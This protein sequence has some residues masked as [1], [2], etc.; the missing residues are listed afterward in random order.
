MERYHKYLLIVAALL[1]YAT[2]AQAQYK[3]NALSYTSTGTTFACLLG[4]CATSPPQLNGTQIYVTDAQ[5]S[6]GLCASGGSGALAMLLNGQWECFTSSA[7][8]AGPGVPAYPLNAQV[9]AGADSG[10][11]INA[12]F[13]SPFCTNGCVVTDGL[14]IPSATNTPAYSV[15]YNSP[16]IWPNKPSKLI[17][18]GL[19]N[20]TGTASAG[21]AV[22]MPG[23]AANGSEIDCEPNATN[24][25]KQAGFAAH[26]SSGSEPVI[27][28]GDKGAI[29]G[30]NSANGFTMHGCAIA[31]NSSATDGIVVQGPTATKVWLDGLTI[32]GDSG[33]TPTG[34]GIHI[35]GTTIPLTSCSESGTTATCTATSALPSFWAVGNT[36]NIIGTSVSGYNIIATITAIGPCASCGA[37]GGALLNTQFQYTAAGSLGNATGGNAYPVGDWNFLKL[38]Y[39]RVQGWTDDVKA[40]SLNQGGGGLALVQ[41]NEFDDS[42]NGS[43][44]DGYFAGTWNG[45][46]WQNGS[47]VTNGCRVTI[48]NT[49][50]G[51]NYFNN[52]HEN[53]TSGSNTGVKDLC[54]INDQSFNIFGNTFHAGT[55]GASHRPDHNIDIDATS[56]NMSIFGN[57]F[58][59]T[60]T[61]QV[62]AAG[63]AK[64]G[65]WNNNDSA[66]NLF[67]GTTASGG[68]ITTHIGGKTLLDNNFGY[69][70]YKNDNTTTLRVAGI[71]ASNTAQLG[72]DGF[73]GVQ[74]GGATSGAVSI[75]GSGAADT[76]SDPLNLL[77]ATTMNNN[78]GYY[79]KNAGGT[80]LRVAGVDAASIAQICNDSFASCNLGKDGVPTTINCRGDITL[81]GGN[82]TFTDNCITSTSLCEAKDITTP[83]NACTVA[84]PAAGSVA[85]TGTASDH[86]RTVCF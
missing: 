3:A 51:G 23:T 52:H 79:E 54:L 68:A 5:I 12:A 22:Q 77:G 15:P 28:I 80:G 21:G 34:Y 36:P 9:F 59:T 16:I 32:N 84:A 74:V 11:K 60:L 13:A 6:A 64:I 29:A 78:L 18:H 61:C 48:S 20:H 39:N 30:I 17:I 47:M 42:T 25:T 19:Y 46:A 8:G 83:G 37:G 26:P 85:I 73:A 81:S 65:Y 72:N 69:Y 40:S 82:G 31:G 35:E 43:L 24:N 67:C 1:L 56:N 10:A 71:D 7:S 44:F 41:Q 63:A 38:T 57:D 45:N 76:I 66:T 55:A 33:S 86:C 75:G 14:T 53:P 58:F 50:G 2:G 4:G 62:N 27:V 70:E 49:A